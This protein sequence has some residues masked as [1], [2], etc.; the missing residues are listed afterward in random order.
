[1]S[2]TGDREFPVD[3][4]KDFHIFGLEWT[5]KEI[6]W[7]LDGKKYHSVNIDR[8]LW[9]GKGKNPYTAHGQPFDAPFFWVLNVAVGGDFFG[10]VPK[11][12]PEQAR[13]WAQPTMEVDYVRVYQQK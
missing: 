8:N 6:S 11:V 1:M 3:F 2:S 10:D 9:S 13:H 5:H 4:S 12:T 7:W